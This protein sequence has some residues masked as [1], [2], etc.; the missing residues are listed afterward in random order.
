M[1]LIFSF[2]VILQEVNIFFSTLII[3]ENKWIYIT[4]LVTLSPEVSHSDSENLVGILGAG[5][6]TIIVN[7][8]LIALVEILKM[9]S[10]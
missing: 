9:F 8:T 5:R 2:I 7:G 3:V 6:N 10:D 1:F 4:I